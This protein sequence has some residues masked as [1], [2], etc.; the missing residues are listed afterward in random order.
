MTPRKNKRDSKKDDPIQ[1]THVE[2]RRGTI[3]RA[4]AHER[5]VGD[6]VIVVAHGKAI[7]QRQAL[8]RHR[9]IHDGDEN[10]RDFLHGTANQLDVLWKQAPEQERDGLMQDPGQQ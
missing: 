8:E 6:Q 2:I 1:K 5:Q 4:L 9:R 10:Q 3:R 7:P